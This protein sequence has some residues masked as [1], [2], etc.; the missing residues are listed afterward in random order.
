MLLRNSLDISSAVTKITQ[1]GLKKAFMEK[2][3]I[4]VSEGKEEKLSCDS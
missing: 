1:L 3:T 2:P 4:Q